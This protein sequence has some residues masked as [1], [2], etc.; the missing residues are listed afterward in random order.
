MVE[1]RSRP[2]LKALMAARELIAAHTERLVIA[3]ADT[4]RGVID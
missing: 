3:G 1:E 2:E 4:T